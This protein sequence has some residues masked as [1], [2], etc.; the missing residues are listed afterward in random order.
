MCPKCLKKSANHTIPECKARPCKICGG[1]HNDMICDQ[2]GGEQKMFNTKEEDGQGGDGNPD[3]SDKSARVAEDEAEKMFQLEEQEANDAY[4][5]PR[6]DEE[7]TENDSLWTIFEYE[8]DM[9]G[10]LDIEETHIEAYW[11]MFDKDTPKEN[12]QAKALQVLTDVSVTQKRKLADT[13]N[14]NSTTEIGAVNKKSRPS[15]VTD[16][17]TGLTSSENPAKT[18]TDETQ[19]ESDATIGQRRINMGRSAHSGISEE[20]YGM[21]QEHIQ[22][23]QTMVREQQYEVE[24]DH[25]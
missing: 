3:D 18:L 4:E 16:N 25:P 14:D 9:A 19:K 13:S 7:L 12:S 15:D 17:S 20:D 24:D 11:S 1:E 23:T 22:P 10:D 6:E 5:E 21:G 8:D 2:D